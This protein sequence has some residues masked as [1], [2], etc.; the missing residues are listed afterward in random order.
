MEVKNFLEVIDTH[1]HFWDL[2]TYG[3]HYGWLQALKPSDREFPLQRS[4]LVKDFEV[5][6][7]GCNVVKSVHVQV[8]SSL[9]FHLKMAKWRL[10]SIRFDIFKFLQGEWRGD[11]VSE[12]KWLTSIAET[13]PRGFPH[14]IVGYTDLGDDAAAAKLDQHMKVSSTNRPMVNQFISPSTR[15]RAHERSFTFFQ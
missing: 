6:I 3:D 10:H 12:T 2:D 1:Q 9:I 5:D 13:N 14:A 11:E 4:Y 15:P 7:E 8:C